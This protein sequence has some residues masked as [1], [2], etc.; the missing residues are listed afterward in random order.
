M[1]AEQSHPHKHMPSSK[2]RTYR[3]RGAKRPRNNDTLERALEL[4]E[5]NDFSSIANATFPR[6]KRPLSW[7]KLGEFACE[8]LK[9]ELST[10][11]SE[12]DLADAVHH[13]NSLEDR[14]KARDAVRGARTTQELRS[15]ILLLSSVA[16]TLAEMHRIRI[17]K[18][19]PTYDTA[20]RASVLRQK[21][22]KLG[23][24]DNS[25][26]KTL[27][28][29]VVATVLAGDS[30]TGLK[31]FYTRALSSW[32]PPPPSPSDGTTVEWDSDVDG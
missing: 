27:F 12:D 30:P 20:G 14:L 22:G 5:S 10:L 15:T 13:A 19:E 4:L 26:V 17:G 18:L 1:G 31:A 2:H 29:Q 9:G 8:S 3:Y 11:R 16:T 23:L 6:I 24:A 32:L 28:E 7:A 25:F 21:W